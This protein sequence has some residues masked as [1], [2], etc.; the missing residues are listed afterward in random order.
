MKQI[1]RWRKQK[2]TTSEYGT[3]DRWFVLFFLSLNYFVLILHR[4]VIYFVQPP[5]KLELDLSDAQIGGLDTAFAVPYALSQLFVGHLGDRFD[6]R[7]ILLLSLTGSVVSLA[8]LGLSGSY[9]MLVG[10]RFLLG[11]S[12]AASVPAIASIMGD[13]FTSRG[14]STAVAVYLVSQQVANIASGSLSGEIADIPSWDIGMNKLGM[15]IVSVS[16][17]RMAM[18]VF[19]LVGAMVVLGVYLFL[20]EPAR[21]DREA[22]R[23]LGLQGGTWWKTTKNVLCVRSFWFVGIVF[24]LIGITSGARETWL[25]RHFYDT[26]GMDLG[27]AGLF[28]TVYFQSG[29]IVGLLFGGWWADRWA[30]RRPSGRMAV[31]TIG[32]VLMGPAFIVLGTSSVQ[33]VL[34][35]AMT[36]IGVGYGFYVA[37]LW[38]TTFEIVDPA[39]RATSMAFLNVISLLGAPFAPLVGYGLDNE[40]F[41]LGQVLTSMSLVVTLAFVLLIWTM[42]R[43]L[44]RDYRGSVK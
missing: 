33:P 6:R 30:S 11:M 22:G 26:L 13:C 18:F 15:H 9:T 39:A 44:P 21:T 16:G 37:N 3:S 19:S 34:A 14:R 25:A 2:P 27:E 36:A 28:S 1:T 10:L 4:N 8:G 20:R 31:Q 24:V 5:L 43:L 40:L 42:V 12:Q 38:T 17:W 23:G 35:V 32:L 7:T 41:D 29:A